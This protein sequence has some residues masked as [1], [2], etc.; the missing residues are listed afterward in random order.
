MEKK[1][2]KIIAFIIGGILLYAAGFGTSFI[3]NKIRE[4]RSIDRL[5]RILGDGEYTGTRVYEGLEQRIREAEGFKE[6]V[7][8]I[9]GDIDGCLD[10]TEQ[11]GLTLGQLG[12]TVDGIGATSSSIGDTIRQLKTGQSEIKKYVGELQDNNSRLE[13]ELRRIYS[14]VKEQ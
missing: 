12:S 3:I 13:E 4:T 5:E 9:E 11:S 8:G 10:I 6:T 1:I 2:K 7:R 14:S